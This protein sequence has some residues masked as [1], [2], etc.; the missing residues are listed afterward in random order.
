[1]EISG[2]KSRRKENEENRRSEKLH[3]LKKIS[4]SFC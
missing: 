1:M 3:G 2:G 4:L